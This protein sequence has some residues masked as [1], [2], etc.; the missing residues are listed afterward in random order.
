MLDE[1]KND[2][3]NDELCDDEMRKCMFT[4][5]GVCN[6][7]GISGTKITIP[8]QKLTKLRGGIYGYRT[9][10]VIRYRCNTRN[11]NQKVPNIL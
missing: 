6:Q 1:E 10:S 5:K 3:I 7:H 11:S 4:R 9:T 2:V 8:R